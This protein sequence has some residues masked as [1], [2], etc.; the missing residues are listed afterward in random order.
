MLKKFTSYV[1]KIEEELSMSSSST[2][3][4]VF[5][6]TGSETIPKDVIIVH[7]SCGVVGVEARTFRGKTVCNFS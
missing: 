3:D 7:F 1:N 6:Y 5:Q 4:E 2:S